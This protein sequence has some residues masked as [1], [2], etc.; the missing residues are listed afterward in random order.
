MTLGSDQ[1]EENRVSDEIARSHFS[2]PK[3]IAGFSAV[4][5]ILVLGI[6]W[7]LCSALVE[8]NASEERHLHI[9]R[10]CGTIIHLDEV[11]TMSAK[12][13]AATGNMDWKERYDRYEL[14]LDQAIQQAEAFVPLSGPE[15]S[16]DI[17]VVNARLVEMEKEAFRLTAQGMRQE[18]MALLES[19]Q[20]R[21]DKQKYSVA[22]QDRVRAMLEDVRSSLKKQ[23]WESRT[24]IAGAVVVMCLIL[25]TGFISTKAMRQHLAQ[26]KW[27]EESLR[28]AH[29]TLENK[30]EERTAELV[31]VN[32]KL[33]SEIAQRQHSEETARAL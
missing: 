4:A 10:L 11:L 18:A 31:I 7:F 20:Y 27:T 14:T 22:T 26:L 30:V 13:C 2:T 6:V 3:L 17:S 32:E 19:D 21:L 8:V 5:V 23:R 15:P 9:Q 24:I 33:R 16:E 25:G 1:Q 12:M 28:E 29:E